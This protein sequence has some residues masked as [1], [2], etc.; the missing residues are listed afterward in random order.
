MPREGIFIREGSLGD[1]CFLL[2]IL[3]VG[4]SCL[5]C[6]DKNSSTSVRREPNIG[7]RRSRTALGDRCISM[8]TMFSVPGG[9]PVGRGRRGIS[10]AWLSGNSFSTERVPLG[11]RGAER[12]RLR[13]AARRAARQWGRRRRPK[14]ASPENYRFPPARVNL[15]KEVRR[16]GAP[17]FTGGGPQGRTAAVAKPPTLALGRELPVPTHPR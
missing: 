12:P 1:C 6:P 17:P 15:C 7:V 2:C 16:G 9:T 13:E 5:P 4:D 10:P 8:P 3:A 11:V 14:G